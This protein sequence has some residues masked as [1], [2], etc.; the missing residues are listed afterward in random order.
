MNKKL[1][2][3][4]TSMILISGSLMNLNAHQFSL[5]DL[6]FTSATAAEFL[7][8]SKKACNAMDVIS[9][10]CNIDL[11]EDE[12]DDLSDEEFNNQHD[13]F[14]QYLD[15]CRQASKIARSVVFSESLSNFRSKFLN[16]VD[17][18]K[19]AVDQGD[20]PLKKFAKQY[21]S[22]TKL[23]SSMGTLSRPESK[24]KFIQL[25]W[26]D[27]N[28]NFQSFKDIIQNQKQI[29]DAYATKYDDMISTDYLRN[30]CS[31]YTRSNSDCKYDL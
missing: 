9:Y 6:G 1:S 23:L 29:I 26:K 7:K 16:R 27:K 5:K 21:N 20:A 3:A 22:L 15:N 30:K 25:N 17:L 10:A 31:E 12:F 2:I 24:I 4:L 11:F 13:L 28:M 18:F 8:D 19:T 14:T